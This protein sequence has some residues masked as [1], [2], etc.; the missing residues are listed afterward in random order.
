[1]LNVSSE[2]NA[3]KSE[4]LR[5]IEAYPKDEYSIPHRRGSKLNRLKRISATKPRQR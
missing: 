3:N 1:M 5:P 2:L 4:E